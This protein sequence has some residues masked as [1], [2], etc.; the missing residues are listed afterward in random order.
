MEKH[1]TSDKEQVAAIRRSSEAV[2]LGGSK[3]LQQEN[4][5]PPLSLVRPGDVRGDKWE[6]VILGN[7]AGAVLIGKVIPGN[8]RIAGHPSDRY[9]EY[10][11]THRTYI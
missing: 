9:L 8:R 7:R 4:L 10:I 3:K 11:C 1:E 2:I 5:Q 6:A